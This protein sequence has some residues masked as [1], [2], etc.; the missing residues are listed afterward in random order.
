M[1]IRP[2]ADGVLTL[3]GND[4]KSRARYML[5]AFT[6]T[7]PEQFAGVRFRDRFGTH[8]KNGQPTGYYAEQGRLHIKRIALSAGIN[9]ETPGDLNA[10]RSLPWS[11]FANQL[12]ECRRRNRELHEGNPGAWP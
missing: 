1:K 4:P 7:A 9:L 12:Q 8:G 10:P 6:V 3:S 11:A 2:R 5:V